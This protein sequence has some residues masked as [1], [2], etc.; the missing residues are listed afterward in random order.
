MAGTLARAARRA[1]NCAAAPSPMQPSACDSKIRVAGL[2]GNAT[3]QVFIAIE[4][5]NRAYGECGRA[6]VL[7]YDGTGVQDL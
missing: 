6:R 1:A 5:G 7:R 2:W 3:D 4:D